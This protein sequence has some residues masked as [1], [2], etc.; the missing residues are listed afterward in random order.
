MEFNKSSEIHFKAIVESLQDVIMRF[1]R[2]HRHLY[3]NQAAEE[4]T[5]IA[6]EDFIGK[7]HEKLG[8]PDDLC[9]LWG[10]AI[11]HVFESK[12]S[13]RI[14]FTLP[15]KVV[16][17]WLMTPEF[18]EEGCFN[19]IL[20]TARDITQIRDSE[21]KLVDN[22]TRFSDAFQLARLS[23]WEADFK[24]KKTILNREFCNIIGITFDEQN[25]F[26]DSNDYFNDYVYKDDKTL[27]INKFK[28]IVRLKKAPYQE[29]FN[30]RIVRADG[31]MAWIMTTIRQRIDGNGDVVGAY[32][33]FQDI[34]AIKKTEHELEIHKLHLED[35]VEHRTAELKKSEH[36]LHD[37]IDLA[38]LSTW[39]FDIKTEE[40]SIAGFL[41]RKLEKERFET[42]NTLKLD[43]FVQDIHPDDFKIFYAAIEKA[44]ITTDDNYYDIIGFRMYNSEKDMQHVNVTIKVHFDNS[45]SPFQLYGTIQDVTYLVKSKNEKE[46]LTS[47]IEATSDI[48]IIT[49]A[50][51]DIIYVN[52]AGKVFFNF[53]KENELTD[54]SLFSL[55]S[56]VTNTKMKS[57][58]KQVAR[59]GHWNGESE[60]KRHDGTLVPVSEV[61]LTHKNNVNEIDCYSLTLR[62]LSKQ[63]QIENDL[64]Y[65]NKE[66]DTFVYRA[67]HDLRGP[68]ASLLGLYNV[69]KH[70]VTDTTALSF[71]DMY[72]DQIL[73][74]NETIIALIELTR[75]KEQDIKKEKIDINEIVQVSISYFTHLN[76]F[77]DINFNIDINVETAIICDK[78]LITTIVQNLIENAIKYSRN[79][80]SSFTNVK[81]HTYKKSLFIIVEDNGV[82]IEESIQGKIFDMFFRA[83]TYAIGSGLGL[84]ILKNAVDKLKGK[85][86]LESKLNVGSTFT[87]TIPL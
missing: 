30:Y 33:T 43:T 61:I 46:R 3:V 23:T 27:F 15:N 10:Q 63:K 67:S 65:K 24:N 13:H 9:Q 20:T 6:R 16:I 14:E 39:Q 72:N 17:D 86:N 60:L 38:K 76:H 53:I 44:L 80:V 32:G 70:E 58:F 81:I 75:I 37:A 48:V 50:D 5:G 56:E 62:D 40:L 1:D 82:G 77:E 11:N 19:T 2:Q 49:N 57:I 28:E 51:K 29:I 64:L 26:M 69:A 7:T 78:S 18:D 35:L 71:F 87:V 21:N 8:F 52:K 73:R 25:P 59:D 47:I 55:H 36:K 68:I 85:V 79:D 74:L 22:Q 54:K 45:N 12:K 42:K 84:Y 34:T 31:E 41:E 4:L 83:N 66:L